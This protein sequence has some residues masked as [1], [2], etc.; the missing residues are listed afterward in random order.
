VGEG[1][2]YQI[3]GKDE[4]NMKKGKV[5]GDDSRVILTRESEGR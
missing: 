5:G 1:Y 4:R 2:K 3:Q